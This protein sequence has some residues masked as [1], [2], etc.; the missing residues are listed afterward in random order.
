MESIAPDQN[1]SKLKRGEVRED[2]MVFW[3]I[4]SGKERWLTAEKF[5]E[6]QE[7]C[8]QKYLANAEK[9]KAKAKEKY[10]ENPELFKS[11]VKARRN[12][13]IEAS[14]KKEAEDRAAHPEKYQK[15][16]KKWYENN[17][18]KVA[19]WGKAYA[20]KNRDKINAFGA[21]WRKANLAKVNKWR[22]ENARK[23]R[24]NDHLFALCQRA[25]G[26][27]AN[28]FRQ[29]GFTK[30]S[31]TFEM[32]GCD[33]PTLSAHIESLFSEGMNFQNRNL[34][35]IDHIIPLASAKTK[36]EVIKLCHYKNLQ[37]LWI[38]DNLAKS[39]KMPWE[40]KIP[41]DEVA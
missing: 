2:G 29:N 19:A 26:R 20:E 30:T 38:A 24:A 3:A 21:K 10:N 39:D 9:I 12:K 5:A 8:R 33:W 28:A 11:K 22:A 27:I 18:A 40:L 31:T 36:E 6:M 35:H 7:S 14:R 13:D 15:W 32:I 4:M 16:S 1:K 37:P 25:R 23:R 17:K 34:W 41:V